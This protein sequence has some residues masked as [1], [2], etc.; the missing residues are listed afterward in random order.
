MSIAAPTIDFALSIGLRDLVVACLDCG[1]RFTVPLSAIDLPGDTRLAE[2]A[3]LRPL[4]CIECS[5]NG[6]VDLETIGF[7]GSIG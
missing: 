6:V 2:I 7:A 1:E 4:P 5:G 3:S